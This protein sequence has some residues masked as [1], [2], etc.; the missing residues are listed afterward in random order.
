M[1]PMA[2]ATG[3]FE[4]LPLLAGQGLDQITD[5]P[6]AAEVIQRMAAEAI[7]ALRTRPGG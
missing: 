5:V 1:V 7:E 2:G 6:T 4:E 3:D